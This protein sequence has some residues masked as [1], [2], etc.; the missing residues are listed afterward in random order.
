MEFSCGAGDSGSSIVPA[1]A[2]LTAM[3]RVRFL[4][5]ELP[6]AMSMAKKKKKKNLN[7]SL[8]VEPFLRLKGGTGKNNFQIHRG[9]GN[10]RKPSTLLHL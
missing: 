10:G 3:T 1:A 4:A 5:Q 6:R 2:W 8:K 9:A 7:I